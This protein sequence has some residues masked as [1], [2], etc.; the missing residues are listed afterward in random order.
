MFGKP[1]ASGEYRGS[2]AVDKSASSSG[3]IFCKK[4]SEIPKEVL[5][6][7]LTSAPKVDL[8]FI[9]KDMNGCR[10]AEHFYSEAVDLVGKFRQEN[11]CHAEIWFYPQLHTAAGVTFRTV[12]D[13]LN[14]GLEVGRKLGMTL[15]LLVAVRSDMP[16]GVRLPMDAACA[17]ID[18]S[19]PSAES[20]TAWATVQQ[21]INYNHVVRLRG[22]ES[23][24]IVGIA[25]DGVSPLEE[26]YH[27]AAENNLLRVGSASTE[28]ELRTAL[29]TLGCARV[30]C[31]T[32]GI[33]S[34]E[35]SCH[36]STPQMCRGVIEAYGAPH[37]ISVSHAP[38]PTLCMLTDLGI[39]CTV[40]CKD[41]RMIATEPSLASKFSIAAVKNLLCNGI[42]SAWMSECEKMVHFCRL[43]DYFITSLE[44]LGL[45]PKASGLLPT[46]YPPMPPFF[47]DPFPSVPIMAT[48]L[49]SSNQ[50]SHFDIRKVFTPKRYVPPPPL[51]Q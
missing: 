26:I 34:A 20:A 25:G 6:Q 33:H 16:V 29:H 37:K 18:T 12:V 21:A 17:T 11:V 28:D 32:A 5:A 50:T 14:A 3:N 42:E 27:F 35:I 7:L 51:S 44:S 36:L 45:L 38:L 47:S 10:T 15:R 49:A 24:A 1:K 41:V 40:L 8:D 23:W 30:R 4:L 48:P 13:G 9:M 31:P 46:S 2:G 19:L 22:P 43:A 39:V